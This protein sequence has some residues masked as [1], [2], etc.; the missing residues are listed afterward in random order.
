MHMAL[1]KNRLIQN[2]MDSKQ[3]WYKVTSRNDDL[4]GPSASPQQY[5]DPPISAGEAQCY[6]PLLRKEAHVQQQKYVESSNL[7]QK[8]KKLTLIVQKNELKNIT[9]SINESNSQGCSTI[10]FPTT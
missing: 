6:T 5:K 3:K 9:V 2:V 7:F 4:R 8:N 10:L 1:I